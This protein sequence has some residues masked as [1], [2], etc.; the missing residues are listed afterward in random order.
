MKLIT[1]QFV[2]I[3]SSNSLGKAEQ[4]NK[5]WYLILDSWEISYSQQRHRYK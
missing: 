5:A 2:D 3:F 4:I 1:Q